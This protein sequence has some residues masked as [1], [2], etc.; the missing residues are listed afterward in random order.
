MRRLATRVL[1][2]GNRYE[3]PC[4]GYKSRDLAAIGLDIP[5]L[6]EQQVAGGGR[7]FAGCYRCGST[8]R[9]RLILT[10]LRFDSPL[11]VAPRTMRVLHMAPEARLASALRPLNFQEY[12]GGDLFTEGYEYPDWVRHIDIVAVPFAAD[13]FDLVICNHV[14]EHVPD[15]RLAMREILRVLKPGGT[16][17]LQVPISTTLAET[18]EDATVTAYQDREAVFGQFDHVRLYG[19]DYAQRLEG[20]GF[21]VDVRDT[22]TRFAHYGLNPNERLYIATKPG[23]RI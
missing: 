21:R 7:R 8:D 19:Q 20:C 17:V 5:V 13:Y 12:I 18:L 10:Y 11:L 6:R 22:S 2:A 16:A 9:E 4:C 15:D 23:P 14:L 1:H 3:C